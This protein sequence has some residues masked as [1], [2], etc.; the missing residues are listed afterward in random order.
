MLKLLKEV[1]VPGINVVHG[2][3]VYSA[4]LFGDQS[5]VRYLWITGCFL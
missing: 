4:T 1:D 3:C 2:E 5:Q